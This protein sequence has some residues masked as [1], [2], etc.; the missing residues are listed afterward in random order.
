M[1]TIADVGFGPRLSCSYRLQLL[2]N[3]ISRGAIQSG[4][5]SI[6]E[7]LVKGFR[8]SIT[9]ACITS[10]VPFPYL[11]SHVKVNNTCLMNMPKFLKSVSYTMPWCH[12]FS[13][14]IWNNPLPPNPPRRNRKEKSHLPPNLYH[15]WALEPAWDIHIFASNRNIANT[16][17]K[18]TAGVIHRE[19]FDRAKFDSMVDVIWTSPCP[20]TKDSYFAS[21]ARVG[22]LFPYFSSR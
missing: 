18:E 15:P 1:S 5:Q 9:F 11:A 19:W 6:S 2:L 8:R 21:Y 12:L 4:P 20:S 10:S 16:D 13:H 7:N 3:L 22:I 14:P 17:L